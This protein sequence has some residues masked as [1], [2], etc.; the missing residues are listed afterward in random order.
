MDNLRKNLFKVSSILT[1]CILLIFLKIDVYASSLDN[2]PSPLGMQYITSRYNY[3]W[4]LIDSIDNSQGSN[5]FYVFGYR[6]NVNSNYT[7]L[8]ISEYNNSW[9]SLKYTWGDGEPFTFI[10]SNNKTTG[11]FSLYSVSSISIDGVRYYYK[12]LTPF[13]GSTYTIKDD[14]NISFN[15][16]LIT[17][18]SFEDCIRQ[19]LNLKIEKQDLGFIK[20]IGYHVDSYGLENNPVGTNELI[21]W[22]QYSTT[23]VDLSDQRYKVEFALRDTSTMTNR[24][25]YE[26]FLNQFPRIGVQL[27]PINLNVL[28][29]TSFLALTGQHLASMF[30][31]SGSEKQ[32]V[33]R[34][35]AVRTDLYG[36]V[37]SLGLYSASNRK[38]SLNCFGAYKRYFADIT[39]NNAFKRYIDSVGSSPTRN[40]FYNNA[41]DYFT[42]YGAN[43]NVSY[44]IMARIVDSITGDKGDWVSIN[45]HNTPYIDSDR[46]DRLNGGVTCTTG[47]TLG[48]TVINEGD[49]VSPNVYSPSY[50]ENEG[51]TAIYLPTK[52]ITGYVDNSNFSSI[53]NNYYTNYEYHYGDTFIYNEYPN[54]GVTTDDDGEVQYTDD[55]NATENINHA[56]RIFKYIWQKYTTWFNKLFGL[57]LPDWAKHIVIISLPISFT[58]ILFKIAKQILPLL[59]NLALRLIEIGSGL[60]LP[61]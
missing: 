11:T 12:G 26:S 48:D 57:W 13:A 32:A 15:G 3:P 2:C 53:V 61:G 37:T 55:G 1:A 14:N 39:E 18:N 40:D 42:S 4:L 30:Y 17:G 21:S 43:Y 29:T 24:N 44:D 50:V 35:Q 45:K 5:P 33:L 38:A 41:K 54:V 49:F 51:D 59:G 19:F 8:G 10:N 58:G 31:P 22:G 52:I 46:N 27:G 56:L 34:G 47:I 16:V 20:N 25:M 7:L 6:T 60:F 36:K 9:Y 23:D 28:E